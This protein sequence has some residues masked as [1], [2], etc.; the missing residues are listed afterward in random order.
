VTHVIIIYVTAYLIGGLG[1]FHCIIGSTEVLL[2]MFAGA[3]ITWGSWLG[4]F[5]LPTT[6]GNIVGGVIFV[7][8]LKGLQAK[9]AR[10]S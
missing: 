5:L 7:T 10:G 4:S 2:G 6:I 3:P 9:S 8:G 1:L